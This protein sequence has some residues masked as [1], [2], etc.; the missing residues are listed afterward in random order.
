MFAYLLV[1][2]AEWPPIGKVAARSACEVFSWCR[3]LIVSFFFVFF[4]FFSHLGFWS[5]ILFL[6]APF[7]D[8]C[9]LVLFYIIHLSPKKLP[10]QNSVKL[11]LASSIEGF[12]ND[13][14][15]ILTYIQVN[16]YITDFTYFEY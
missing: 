3:C 12:K 7:P 9:L 16:D 14:Y 13:H 5:G 4:F 11:L 15:Q 8:L 2:V 6:I 10:T 1:K